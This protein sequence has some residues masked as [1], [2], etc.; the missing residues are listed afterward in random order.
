ML[1]FSKSCKKRENFPKML[2]V[3]AVTNHTEESQKIKVRGVLETF[4]LDI[5]NPI[6]FIP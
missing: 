2:H 6:K 4:S 1:Y 3:Q 5:L